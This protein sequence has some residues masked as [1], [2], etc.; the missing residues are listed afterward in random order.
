SGAS[1]FEY[2]MGTKGD[3]FGT[4]QWVFG[5]LN[6]TGPLPSSKMMRESAPGFQGCEK[7]MLMLGS[8]DT[9]VSFGVLLS[10]SRLPVRPCSAAFAW[11][12]TTT[13]KMTAVLATRRTFDIRVAARSQRMGVARMVPVTPMVAM[14]PP[15]RSENG[16]RR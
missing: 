10:R 8:L 13:V 9:S 15:A 6:V 3:P 14:D 4:R 5:K 7:A 1:G 11:L 2:L 16:T 12:P